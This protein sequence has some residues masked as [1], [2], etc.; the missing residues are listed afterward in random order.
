[1]RSVR[2]VEAG[3]TTDV[4]ALLPGLRAALSGKGPALLPV[5][6]DEQGARVVRAAQPDVPGADDVALLLPTSGSTGEPKVVELSA[7][8]LLASARATHERIGGPGRWLLSL[9]VSHVAGWQVLVRAVD[10]GH[11]PTVV[12]MSGR[13]TVEVFSA[14]VDRLPGPRCYGSLVPTQLRRLLATGP[15]V[16][17][18]RRLDA[19]LVGG[20]ATPPPL[21]ERARAEGVRVVTTY[22]MT[23]TSGGC[24]YDGR[25]LDGVAVETGPDGRLLIAGPVLARGYRNRP[26]LTDAAFPVRDGRRWF[27]TSDVG[28]LAAGALVLHGRVDDVVVSGGRKVAPAAVESVLAGLPGVEHSVVVGVPD[29]EWGQAVVALVVGQPPPLPEVRRAVAAR[30]GGAAAPR[31][32]L[33]VDALPLHGIGKPDRATAADLAGRLVLGDG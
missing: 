28:E 6:A 21:L 8:A 15:G 29:D 12:D 25:P 16:D 4:L 19:V 30:L 32:L 9:P 1:M 22:G 3:P 26:D 23:E 33:V 13:F 5:P 31:H 18:L 7:D 14:G 20:A 17:A 27:A 2:V 10:A 11:P 24:V